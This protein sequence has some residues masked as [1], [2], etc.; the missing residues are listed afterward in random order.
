MKSRFRVEIYEIRWD[1][2][3][4]CDELIKSKEGGKYFALAM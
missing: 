2:T 3:F 1:L 4:F